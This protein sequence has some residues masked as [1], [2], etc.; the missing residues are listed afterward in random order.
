MYR[1]VLLAYD[2]SESGRC[3]LFECAEF[4]LVLRAELHLLAVA[5]IMPA[6]YVA[7]GLL[8][9]MPQEDENDLYARVLAEGLQ[10]LAKRGLQ[11]QGHLVT[12]EPVGEIARMAGELKV[13]LIMVGHTHQTSRMARWWQG[14][15]STSLVEAS[16]CSVLVAVSH[17]PLRDAHSR[18]S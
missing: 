4:N 11:V 3:A 1:K 18:T 5:P 16:P 13:D 10:M 8:P 12:G 17:A 14:S 6:I 15:L 7:D 9:G 2:G